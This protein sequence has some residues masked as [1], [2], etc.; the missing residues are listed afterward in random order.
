MSTVNN[1]PKPDRNTQRRARARAQQE[2]IG[3]QQ[4]L[5]AERESLTEAST[6]ALAEAARPCIR[7]VYF[8]GGSAGDIR[9]TFRE[10]WEYHIQ[11]FEVALECAEDL[12]LYGESDNEAPGDTVMESYTVHDRVELIAQI[13]AELK[14]GEFDSLFDRTLLE[15]VP[16]FTDEAAAELAELKIVFKHDGGRG[17]DTAER[18]DALR[19][20]Q[21]LAEQQRASQGKPDSGPHHFSHE[22]VAQM[23][24]ELTDSY[25]SDEELG[26]QSVVDA[27]VADDDVL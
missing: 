18:I 12:L 21:Q 25:A 17:V 8:Y 6:G 5:E 9:I 27:T 7:K 19:R 14:D 22:E 24:R 3:Y 13:K 10:F 15:T 11:D 4:A 2:G 23:R 16:P 26:E 20:W 1:K